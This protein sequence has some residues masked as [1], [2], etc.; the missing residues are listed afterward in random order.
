MIPA[1]THCPLTWTLEYSGYL[2]S[3]GSTW[4]NYYR[5]MYECVDKNPDSIPMVSYSTMLK[6]TA[7][8]WLV[9]LTTDRKNSPV[10]FVPNKIET[11]IHANAECN[12]C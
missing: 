12:L 5:T 6:L 10:Q 1:K 11:T 9:H 8:E 4:S 7:M 3:E 2:M